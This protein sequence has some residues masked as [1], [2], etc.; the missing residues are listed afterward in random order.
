MPDL[1]ARAMAIRF[2]NG[3]H[4]GY[5]LQACRLGYAWSGG[6]VNMAPAWNDRG[7]GKIGLKGPVFWKSPAGFPW[8]VTESS[9]PIPDF[10]GRGS[11]VSLGAILKLDA[12]FRC[13]PVWISSGYQLTAGGPT[14]RYELQLDGGQRAKFHE[15]AR[16]LHT[17][18]ADGVLRDATVEAPAGRIVWLNT[19]DADAA[20]QWS[21]ADGHSGQLD[22][23]DKTAPA[24]ALVRSM[25]DGKP[26]LLHLRSARR[27][28]R[29]G[30]R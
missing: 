30:K 3:V 11:D 17:D 24:E 26:L 5:D 9:S 20:P 23:I 16:S 25:Q 12:K 19:A 6:F 10:S 13:R 28:A 14:F 22:E 4:L 8:D 2:D 27:R 18:L 7:G 21:T 29:C 1:S 15:T